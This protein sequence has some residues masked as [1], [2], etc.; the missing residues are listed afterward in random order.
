MFA[1]K[2]FSFPVDDRDYSKEARKRP[3]VRATPS[4]QGRF[5]HP[6]AKIIN[7]YLFLPSSVYFSRCNNIL[8]KAP[9][10]SVIII[11]WEQLGSSKALLVCI[12]IVFKSPLSLFVLQ[13]YLNIAQMYVNNQIKLPPHL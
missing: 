13:E 6:L 10:R 11:T 5:L 8:T 12:F 7:L 1:H 9:W 4:L 3:V 2:S